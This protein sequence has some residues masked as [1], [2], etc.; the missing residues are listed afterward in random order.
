M[1]IEQLSVAVIGL[2]DIARKAYLPVLGTQADLR[3]RLMTR[4]R[5]RLAELGG[6][7]HVPDECRFTELAAVLDGSAVCGDLDAA[8]VHVA[9]VAHL[10]VVT[11]LLDAGVPTYVDKP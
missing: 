6:A 7:Y 11:T 10:E 2:G 4:N 9:T 8:F 3:L 5:D 1:E